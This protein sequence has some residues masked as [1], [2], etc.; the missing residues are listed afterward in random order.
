MPGMPLGCTEHRIVIT[1][2]CHHTALSLSTVVAMSA[3]PPN[4][5]VHCNDLIFF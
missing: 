2:P 3:L 5:S 4:C 1:L